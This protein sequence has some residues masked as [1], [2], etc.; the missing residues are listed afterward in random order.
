MFN[1]IFG[2]LYQMMLF[3][4]Y[5]SLAIH[6]AKLF[7]KSDEKTRCLR[8]AVYLQDKIAYHNSMCQFY[9]NLIVDPKK[10]F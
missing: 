10:T 2:F 8:D 5:G 6:A 3:A 4:A 7:F 9:S 1:F